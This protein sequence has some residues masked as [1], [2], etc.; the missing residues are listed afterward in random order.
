MR[1]SEY[2]RLKKQIEAEYRHKLESLETVWHMVSTNGSS[3]D[4]DDGPKRRNGG[5]NSAI[6]ALL[7]ALK[8]EATFNQPTVLELLKERSP[9][10]GATSA[11]VSSALRRLEQDGLIGLVERG[12]GQRAT[13]YSVLETPAPESV[14]GQ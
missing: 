3:A 14:Q 1:K 2:L 12:A 7:P 6:K 5:L 8:L 4:G 9:E 13:T 11:S 10:L